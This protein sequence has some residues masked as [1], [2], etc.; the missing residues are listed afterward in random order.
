MIQR[1]LFF[2]NCAGH[3]FYRPPSQRGR[4]CSLFCYHQSTRQDASRETILRWS[5]PEP[6]SG[7]WLWLS[8]CT[9]QGYGTLSTG[10]KW[11]LAHRLSYEVFVGPIPE[12]LVVR[13]SCD[14]PPCVN[15]EHLLIGTNKDNM[16]DAVARGRMEHGS[17][18]WSARLREEDIPDVIGRLAIGETCASIGRLCSS[19]SFRQY[20]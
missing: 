19:Q 20:R 12:G 8:A 11:R 10:M 14:N 17:S 5:M 9:S 6:N 16:Q 3:P 1:E 7:C 2:A 4:F 13:H 15:P 18:R